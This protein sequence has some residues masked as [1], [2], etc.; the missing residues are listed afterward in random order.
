MTAPGQPNDGAYA[1]D[2]DCQS[3]MGAKER[4]ECNAYQH[5]LLK[6]P[7]SPETPAAP[8]PGVPDTIGSSRNNTNG[9]PSVDQIPG[10]DQPENR[11]GTGTQD[12]GA[13]VDP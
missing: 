5:N 7:P 6:H 11:Q 1:P 8:L 3:L 2:I 10:L 9:L 12:S 13:G 4:L